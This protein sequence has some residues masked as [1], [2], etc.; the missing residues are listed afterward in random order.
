MGRHPVT[1][2]LSHFP[3]VLLEFFLPVGQV[4]ISLCVVDQLNLRRQLR[5]RNVLRT[6]HRLEGFVQVDEVAVTFKNDPRVNGTRNFAPATGAVHT[7]P[8]KLRVLVGT[9]AFLVKDNNLELDVLPDA[10]VLPFDDLD[11]QRELSPG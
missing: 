5:L 1:K 8:V 10:R 9:W 3:Q 11:V 4:G 7:V 6:E 2:Q